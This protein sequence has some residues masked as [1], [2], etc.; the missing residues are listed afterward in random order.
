MIP[1]TLTEMIAGFAVILS[2]ILV[3]V[4]SLILRT[5]KAGTKTKERRRN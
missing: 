2:I 5:R 4:L 1:N 3:Y